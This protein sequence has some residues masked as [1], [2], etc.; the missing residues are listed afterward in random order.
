LYEF[1]TVQ[2]EEVE[3]GFLFEN[4][5]ASLLHEPIYEI[6]FLTG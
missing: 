4:I 2:F 5:S 6:P 1:G 3:K